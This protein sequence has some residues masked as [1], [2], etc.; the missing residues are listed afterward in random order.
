MMIKFDAL[1]FELYKELSTAG[2][3]LF[4]EDEAIYDYWPEGFNFV[5]KPKSAAEKYEHKQLKK[6]KENKIFYK[7]KYNAKNET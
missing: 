2:K 5:K 4:W 1:H 7:E 6:H 3:T